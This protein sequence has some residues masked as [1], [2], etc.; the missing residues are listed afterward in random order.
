MSNALALIPGWL[1]WAEKQHTAGKYMATWMVFNAIYV[2]EHHQPYATFKE[3]DGKKV[4][5]NRYGYG[6]QMVDVQT[7]SERDMIQRALKKLPTKFKRQLIALPLPDT[8]DTCLGFFAR[9][10]PVWQ[11][12]EIRQDARGQP[13]RGVVNVRQTTSKAY[14]RWV[15]VDQEMLNEVLDQLKAGVEIDVP[16]RLI[17]QLGDVLYTVRNNLFH[18]C[19]GPEDSN[20]TE[21]LQN[22]LYLLH[23]IVKFYIDWVDEPTT[24]TTA[25]ESSQ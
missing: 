9:R 3:E 5:V 15:P 12:D 17:E 24:K 18:G 23:A 11:G 8:D 6:Y 2:A 14:P 4:F 19:K 13:V 25:S 10:V 22:A 20:D 16:N 7:A 21:V 1:R